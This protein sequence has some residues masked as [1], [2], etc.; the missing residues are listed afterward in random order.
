[1]YGS[2]CGGDGGAAWSRPE[3]LRGYHNYAYD[4]DVVP[5]LGGSTSVI[6]SLLRTPFN[7]S[8]PLN[9]FMGGQGMTSTADDTFTL[10]HRGMGGRPHG[11]I[12]DPLLDAG[13]KPILDKKG[14]PVLDSEDSYIKSLP[15]FRAKEAAVR[16]LLNSLGPVGGPLASEALNSTMVTRSLGAMLVQ[17]RAK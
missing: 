14:K 11:V 15:R 4:S 12:A 9:P 16:A 17:E 5:T 10:H 8:N 7:R 3:G 2:T 1:M 6:G 13:G